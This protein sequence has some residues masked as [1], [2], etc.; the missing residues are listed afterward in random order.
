[1]SPIE[2]IEKTHVVF[3]DVVIDIMMGY[4]YPYYLGSL[5]QNSIHLSM[6]YSYSHQLDGVVLEL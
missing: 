3:R 6:C 1:M 2:N 4:T 5:L